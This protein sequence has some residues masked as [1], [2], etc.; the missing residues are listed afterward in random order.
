MWGGS[1]GSNEKSMVAFKSERI[2]P[3]LYKITLVDDLKAGVYCFIASTGVT[4]AY[5]AGATTA[6]DLFDFG[7]DTQ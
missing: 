5:A 6:H 3:G 7:V 1:S 4:S 2:R